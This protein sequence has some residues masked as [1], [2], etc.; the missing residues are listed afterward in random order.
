MPS[1]IFKRALFQAANKPTK[2]DSGIMQGFDEDDEEEK[3]DE[4]MDEVNKR[5][6][7]SPEILMNNLRGD[8]RSVDAR[9]QE[10]A[11]MVGEEA[12][13]ETPPEVLAML[14]PQMAQQAPTGIGALPAQGMPPPSPST[15]AAPMPTTPPPAAPAGGIG[16]MLP[17][18]MTPPPMGQEPPAAAQGSAPAPQG[19][20]YGGMVGSA[21]GY[22]PM[23]MM[24][25]PMYQGAM[26]PQGFAM[27]GEVG[28]P[29][30]GI[31]QFKG[32]GMVKNITSQINNNPAVNAVRFKGRP[33]GAAPSAIGSVG[34]AVSQMTM[35][36]AEQ[37]A[38]QQEAQRA[39]AERQR[40]E[41][42]RK[43]AAELA[44]K[45]DK[46]MRTPTV[47]DEKTKLA[48]INPEFLTEFTRRFQAGNENRRFDPFRIQNTQAFNLAGTSLPSYGMQQQPFNFG[49]PQQ[50]GIN[51]GMQQQP[52]NYNAFQ[53]QMPGTA[54]RAML[55][56]NLPL[57]ANGGVVDIPQA[58]ANYTRGT[59]R[60]QVPGDD[61]PQAGT[62]YT[63]SVANAGRNGDNMLVHMSQS[64]ADLLKFM[65]GAGS[66]NPKTG[67]PE[68]FTEEDVEAVSTPTG[69]STGTYSPEVVS[70][71]RSYMDQFL[72]QRPTPVPTL[73]EGIKARQPIYSRL[74]GG[75]DQKQMSQ[76][77][78]LFDIAQR[79]LNFA[80]NVDDQGRPIRG[81]GVQ[82]FAQ[83]FRS[84]PTAIGQE[85]K[86]MDEV[87]RAARLAAFQA[88]EKE[89]EATRAAN[90]KLLE[91][92]RKTF[93]D[94]VKSDG[95]GAFGK[96]LTGRIANM[97]SSD[98][99]TKFAEG[100]T[101]PEQDRQFL[102]AITQ[103]TQP[104]ESKDPVTGNI[105][106]RKPELPSHVTLAIQT[107]N[108]SPKAAL[109]TSTT[110]KPAVPA[111]K[112]GEV[113][114]TTEMADRS[115]A[116]TEKPAAVT[117]VPAATALA[118]PQSMW[119]LSP[120]FAGPVPAVA[121]GVAKVPGFGDLAPQMQQA[122]TFVNAAKRDL[123]K[124]LQNNPR[125]P[126]GERK[127]IEKEIDIGANFLDNTA[128]V[129]NRMVAIDDFLFKRQQNEERASKDD[130]LP[131]ATRQAALQAANELKNFRTTMGVPVRV[132]TIEQVKALPIN[133]K[134]IWNG[135]E[136][137]RQ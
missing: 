111:P 72:N 97:F 100:K 23:S 104:V 66:K 71:A 112:V 25:P 38:A 121:S 130:T 14:Q 46:I 12:A 59:S 87:E 19:F 44:E 18:G 99:V 137:V 114:T 35:P 86:Y 96:S 122:V 133:T 124:N 7:K 91:S 50:Q 109:G 92:Q 106:L 5:T 134:F 79:G 2:N 4:M 13:M 135:Q 64:Q 125:F 76:A 36:T 20:A 113:P 80:A 30:H 28:N 117:N 45:R 132:T 108:L 6:V 22:G 11:D 94:I 105:V 52:F 40:I 16:A 43:A 82:R 51:Y 33:V 118:A 41:A 55:G 120:F 110:E 102:T 61:I 103:Y 119:E 62:V 107:R 3:E 131:T 127:A 93:A 47:T 88:T 15:G 89:I 34:Q 21:A 60:A 95:G 115:V 29:A 27:G 70:Q 101:T 32:G 63:R 31:Q 53:P 26:A 68:Y 90:V 123:I 10:L 9:Y 65:G 58:N 42:E 54:P 17:P 69:G 49:M 48:N 77:R 78:I 98:L 8:M 81:S 37:I 84:L 74:L 39:E 57:Y 24:A 126:E 128:A 67:L 129:K 85:T 1:E 116:T 83:S 136:R 56:G 73:E 75:E